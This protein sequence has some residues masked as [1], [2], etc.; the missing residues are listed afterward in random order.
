MRIRQHVNPH[1]V[2]FTTFR[3]VRPVLPPDRAI[4]V[5]IG[6]ADAQFLFERAARACS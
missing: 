6:C 2:F 3:G 4:E 5:E 1:D